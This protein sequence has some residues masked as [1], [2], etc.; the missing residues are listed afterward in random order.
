MSTQYATAGL[1]VRREWGPP[2]ETRRIS[3]SRG[4]AQKAASSFSRKTA[5]ATASA[6]PASPG[7][8]D[9]AALALDSLSGG[10]S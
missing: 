4:P 5:S 8:T 9:R 10:A 1:G 2:L 7:R 6:Y 3:D